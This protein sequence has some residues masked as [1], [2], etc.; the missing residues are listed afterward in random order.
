MA[1]LYPA[2]HRQAHPDQ[3]G[4]LPGMGLSDAREA[5]RVKHIE[6][7][8]GVDPNEEK[9]EAKREAMRAARMLRKLSDVLDDYERLKLSQLRRGSQ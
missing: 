7:V 3:V 9:R 1:P 6:V 4:S 2:A 5:A 8:E